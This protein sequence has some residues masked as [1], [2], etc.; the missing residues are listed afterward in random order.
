MVLCFKQKIHSAKRLEFTFKYIT[1]VISNHLY[2]LSYICKR[3]HYFDKQNKY[4]NHKILY[5]LKSHKNINPN[6]KF[7]NFA[8]RRRMVKHYI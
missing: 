6:T 3:L 7:P 8:L 5:I 1:K 4:A 2:H